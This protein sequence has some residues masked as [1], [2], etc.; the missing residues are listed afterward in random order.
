MAITE[1]NPMTDVGDM[2][3]TL[4]AYLAFTFAVFG[5]APAVRAARTRLLPR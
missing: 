4:A 2:T 3:S 1:V 5:A